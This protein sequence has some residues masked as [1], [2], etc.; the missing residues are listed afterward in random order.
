MTRMGKGLPQEALLRR[1]HEALAAVRLRKRRP[2]GLDSMRVLKE[3]IQCGGIAQF[4]DA[5][6]AQSD[7][8]AFVKSGS[9][10]CRMIVISNH[11][12]PG[13]VLMLTAAVRDLHRAHSRSFALAADTSCGAL[14]EHN[15]YIEVLNSHTQQN[16]C[17]IQCHYPL[18]H[19]SN[20][21]PYH[22]LHGFIQY[23]EQ[24]LQVRI[25][26]TEFKGDIHL[27]EEERQVPSLVERMGQGRDFWILMAGGKYD[28]TTKWW[29]PRSYQR[30]VDHFRGKILFAQC[31]EASHWHPPL[32]GVVN[33]VGKTD[34]RQ[35]IRLMYHA[36]GVVC[37]VTFAMHL[38]AAVPTKTG[39]LRPCVV[40]AGGR[41]PPHW[42]AYP[43]H[44][45]LHTVGALPCCANGGC[46]RSRCQKVGDGDQKDQTNLCERPVRVDVPVSVNGRHLDSVSIPQ[47]MSMIRPE[48]V[49]RAIESYYEG[50]ILSYNN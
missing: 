19:R 12:A 27:S 47:C 43:G 16:A 46:W 15:P 41:E 36:S 32:N 50:G 20:Q 39:H 45:F 11:Q 22:F 25:P 21:I 5:H 17:L 2:S 23:L 7:P 14:W 24:Q 10:K 29:D 35:F 28:F 33:L 48:D 8:S 9:A 44:R 26:L 38:A 37:P 18:V 49:I 3:S 30:V 40:V 1:R 13:D 4:A 34:L 42:E 6:T 31:G